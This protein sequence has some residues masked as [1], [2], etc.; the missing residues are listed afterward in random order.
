MLTISII[1][2]TYN[3][4]ATICDLVSFIRKNSKDVVQEI[5]VVDGRSEDDTIILA[6]Q[7]GAMV[8]LSPIRNRAAQMNV[9]AQQATGSVLYFV[10]ADV[11]L[12]S[13]FVDD[14]QEAIHQGYNSGCYRYIFDTSRIMLR[15]N[16]YLT[17]FDRM[18]MMRGGDQTL[19][20]EKKVFNALHGF[21][22]YYS[23]MEDYDFII[24][25]RKNYSFKVIQKDIVV[26]AR[27]YETN[28]WLRVQFANLFIFT[29]FRLKR[30][31]ES[32]RMMYK[33]LLNYRIP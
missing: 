16:S 13:S 8:L 29:M 18:L 3:E 28:S 22:E 9:G 11:Q 23:L 17:R 4:A 15:A 7:A 25:L 6:K 20:I 33:K 19:F 12:L 2:P 24:R 30:S 5:F 10:H 32:M 26:S 21:D 31:P 27:K 1:I 14:I